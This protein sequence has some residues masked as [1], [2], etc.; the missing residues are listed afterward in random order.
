M[1]HGKDSGPVFGS[2]LPMGL[3]VAGHDAGRRGHGVQPASSGNEPSELETSKHA[4]ELGLGVIRGVNRIAVVGAQIDSVRR[5][6]KR[7]GEA[8]E[9]ALDLP[10]GFERGSTRWHVRDA[11]PGY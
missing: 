5:R 7:A 9:E 2:P 6:F 3:L 4:A 1:W 11:V 10:E 8:L